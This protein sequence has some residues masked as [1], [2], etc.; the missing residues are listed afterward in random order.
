MK[1]K[2][3]DKYKNRNKPTHSWPNNTV[4][5]KEKLHN[6]IGSVCG[7]CAETKNAKG[8]CPNRL[9]YMEYL[10]TYDKT[11]MMK[12]VKA[13]FKGHVCVEVGIVYK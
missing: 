13:D 4:T 11:E 3:K 2:R 5:V 1:T 10:K 7:R 12:K 9:N 6:P 8:K